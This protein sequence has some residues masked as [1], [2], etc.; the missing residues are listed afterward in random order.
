[1]S[2][3][4]AIIQG[5]MASSRLPGKVMADLGGQPLLAHVIRR[6]K[7]IRGMDQVVVATT[8]DARDKPLLE[9]AE[10]L[11]V[12]GFAGDAEDVLDR[13]YQAARQHSA[14]V[15]MRLTADCPFLDP[16]VSHHVLR[17]FQQEDADYASNAHPPTYPDGLDTEVF[18]IG[19]LERAWKEAT[20]SS[21]R[22]HVT[23]FIWKNPDI[24]R[25]VNVASDR[26]LSAMRWTVDEPEDLEFA[27]SVQ[28]YLRQDRSFAQLD[29]VL[30]VLARH[31]ELSAINAGIV[32]DEGYVKSVRADGQT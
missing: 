31:P 10:H 5:R 4:V 1:M 9:L 8:T 3:V 27:R 29:D 16:Q 28:R 26:D 12:R 7:A 21:E 23:P 24:F 17:R 11:G 18:S 15:I 19:A 6:A 14:T 30:D 22:E 25:L 13:Y 32:R 2:G 20:L